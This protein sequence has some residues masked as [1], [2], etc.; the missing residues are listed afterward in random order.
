MIGLAAAYAQNRRSND[1]GASAANV[2]GSVSVAT[3]KRQPAAQQSLTDQVD[4]LFTA[5]NKPDTPGCALAIVKDGKIIYAKGY[6]TSNLEYGIPITPKSIFHVA[7]DSKQFTGISILMLANQGKLLL[8]DDVRKYI[9]E[10]PDLGYKITLRHLLHHTSGLRDQWELLY[11][12]GWREDDVKTQEDILS[13]VAR[14]Q[15][16]NFKPGD[17]FDYCNTGFTLLAEVVKRVT[18]KTLRQYADENIFKPLGMNR[19]HIHD[20][21]SEIVKDR[22][23]AYETKPGGG[24]KISIPVFDNEGATSLFT[25]VEDFAKWDQNFYDHKVGGDAV[26]EKML[27]PEV[28]N[29]GTKITYAGGVAVDKYR[30]LR[31]ISHNGADAGY[32]SAWVQF[33]D[34]HFS[35][36]CFCNVPEADPFGSVMKIADLYLAGD[37][38]EPAR[39]GPSQTGTKL[40]SDELAALTGTYFNPVTEMTQNL[41]AKDGVLIF[42]Q[43]PGFPMNPVGKNKFT[44]NGGRSAEVIFEKSSSGSLQMKLT[45]AGDRTV[46][47]DK[48]EPVKLSAEQMAEYGNG[49]WSDELDTMGRVSIKDGSLWLEVKRQ[50]AIPLVPIFKDAFSSIIGATVRFTRDSDNH[51][52]GFLLSTGRSRRMKFVKMAGH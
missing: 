20:D 37:F 36:I 52:N 3:G 39:P 9:P 19:T 12:A 35:V 31:T 16:L 4:K 13:L 26:I 48:V 49:Y 14:Q 38:T 2:D 30:G 1:Y 8:D 7:S 41:T 29:D 18:G 11:L 25:T 10:V 50:Q 44:V 21:H 42:A 17:E 34:Q 27:T 46:V 6:G 45:P 47:F 15:A 43:G 23:S 32:R 51:I 40:P 5:W 33:P 24:Y 28:L 22:T